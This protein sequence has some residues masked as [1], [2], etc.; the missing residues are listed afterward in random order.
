MSL[1]VR[2]IRLEDMKQKKMSKENIGVHF[3]SKP[4]IKQVIFYFMHMLVET[5]C[6]L[7]IAME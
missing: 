2:Y 5:S 3:T 4:A 7:V 6:V 1:N